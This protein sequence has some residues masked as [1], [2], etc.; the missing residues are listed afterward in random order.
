[1]EDKQ[2][3][4]LSQRDAKAMPLA[5]PGRLTA[6]KGDVRR[7][8]VC[9]SVLDA[10]GWTP[11]VELGRIGVPHG[12]RILAK[13]EYMN[14]GHSK[15]D[16]IALAMIDEAER[17]GELSPGQTVVELTSGNAG[18]GLAIVCAV[19]GY[20]FVAVMSRGNSPERALLMRALGAEVVLVDQLSES[21][22][23]QVSGGDL[24]LV[25]RETQRIVDG[26]DAF[27]ANQFESAACVDAHQAHTAREILEQS[28][29]GLTACC[30]F[31]GSGSSFSGCAVA[32]KEHDPGIRCYVVEPDGAAALAGRNV[33]DPNHRI[34]GGGYSRERLPLLR[35]DLVDGY[36]RIRDKEAIAAARDLARR[37]ALFAGFSSGANVAA[38]L[39]LLR[40]RHRGGTVVVLLSDSGMKYLS[41]D[42]W[43]M[44]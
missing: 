18:T 44:V 3:C 1:M 6:T 37:E 33:T 12:G 16:R 10:I 32:F 27:R 29:G 23:G 38:A 22:P 39:R 30:D 28:G 4:E 35:S 21:T 26:R 20:P 42:L 5:A 43:S 8:R 31:V 34:Q 15:K 24:D 2:S 40:G 19:R 9:A 14:P 41:T 36:L 13:L 11:L 25:E 17:T 7:T